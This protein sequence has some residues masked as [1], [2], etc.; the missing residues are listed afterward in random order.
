[1]LNDVRACVQDWQAMQT[2]CAPLPRNCPGASHAVSEAGRAEAQE[3]L[4]WAADDH[5]T[6]LGY[7]E[8]EVVA[9]DGDAVLR[10]GP[11][12]GSACS[13]ATTAWANRAP[14]AAAPPPASR[15]RDRSMP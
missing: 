1:V 3:F 7:R 5:F 14:C 4:R 6:F 9:G 15:A 11:A 8:Y 12:P 13:R 2:R 10:A